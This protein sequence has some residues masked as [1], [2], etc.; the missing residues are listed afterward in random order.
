MICLDNTDVIEGGA[1]VDAVVD[2]QIHGLVGTTF[3]QLAAGVLGTTLTTVLYTAAAAVSV[4]SIIL[5]NTHTSAV[6]ITLRLDP[7]DG[8]NPRYLIPKTVSLGI[9][10]SLHTDGARF[11]VFD[12]N[13]ALVYTYVAHTHDGDTLQLD[14]VN[15]DGGA[16][17]FTTSGDVTHSQNLATADGKYLKSD[18]VRARDADGLFLEDDLGDGIEVTRGGTIHMPKQ[19]GFSGY[20]SG[21]QDVPTGSWTTV[22]FNTEEDDI[23]NELNV[24]TYTFTAAKSGSRQV[25]GV[26]Q[27][28]ET[29]A[30][31]KLVGIA[32][33]KNAAAY[34]FL[35]TH[36]ASVQLAGVSVSLRIPLL[37][38][39][40]ILIKVYHNHG[41]NRELESLNCRFSIGKIT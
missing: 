10:Y 18:K 25:S 2:Y 16:F 11:S 33:Y 6:T 15:S 34:T 1:S 4:V 31:D 41:A 36:T 28:K 30:A 21:D 27:F 22:E 9:G 29:I 39:D 24:G 19:S 35:T 26:I 14:G 20:L 32:I 23:Q 40:T 37:A 17:A 3:T 8:G 5:V 38:T 13:G 7:A 12:T